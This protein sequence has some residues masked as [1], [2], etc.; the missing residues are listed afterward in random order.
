MPPAVDSSERG[1]RTLAPLFLRD[2]VAAAE[3]AAE[4][5]GARAALC[6]AAKEMWRNIGGASPNRSAA[7]S[8]RR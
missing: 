4:P 8:K 3:A 1:P 7:A 2:G 5:R 6:D